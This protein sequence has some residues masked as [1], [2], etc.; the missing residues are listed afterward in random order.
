[1]SVKTTPTSNHYDDKYHSYF[2][3]MMSWVG[4][5]RRRVNCR[6]AEYFEADCRLAA[7]LGTIMSDQEDMSSTE[8]WAKKE[9][10]DDLCKMLE[11]N[12]ETGLTD[13][14]VKQRPTMEKEMIDPEEPVIMAQ[15]MRN[16]FGTLFLLQ[17]LGNILNVIYW[18]R[19]K[20]SL[21]RHFFLAS[22]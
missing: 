3:I 6:L 14:Q 15:V 19:R 8:Y 20:E 9:N 17:F 12:V 4:R 1:M 7:A 16:F 11:T 22:F 5:M 13:D 18:N 21:P 2:Y 10:V